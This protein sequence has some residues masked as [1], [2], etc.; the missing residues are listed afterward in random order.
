MNVIKNTQVSANKLR[1]MVALM[2]GGALAFALTSQTAK[3]DSLHGYCGS[4]DSCTTGGATIVDATNPATFYFAY[5]GS[6]NTDT[7]GDLRLEFLVPVSDGS[8]ISS[9][10]VTGTVDGTATLFSSTPWDNK[11]LDG[12][13]GISASPTNPIG[14]YGTSFYVYQV[15]LGS[16]TLSPNG[17]PDSSLFEE[18][19]SGLPIDTY[20]LAFLNTAAAGTPADW[21]ATANSESI[22]DTGAPGT[23]TQTG[24]TPEPSSLML[25]GTGVLVLAAVVRRRYG[26]QLS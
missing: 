15:D 13:L 4:S 21:V 14:S 24:V 8:P 2:I 1:G 9:I 6:G 23:P 20:I 10:T 17:H 19:S 25:L 5:A 16:V 22:L 12:Y 3:A 26:P 11:Q 7:T 18:T